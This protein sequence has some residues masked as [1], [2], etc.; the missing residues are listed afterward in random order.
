M[1]TSLSKKIVLFTVTGLTLLA[2]A[3]NTIEGVGKDI[4]SSGGAIEDAAK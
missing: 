3:C 4:E 2:S 1:K